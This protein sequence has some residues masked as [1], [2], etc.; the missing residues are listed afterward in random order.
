MNLFLLHSIK[1]VQNKNKY[2]AIGGK[3]HIINN[4]NIQ[5]KNLKPIQYLYSLVDEN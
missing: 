3:E 5:S 1:L 2:K 4:W